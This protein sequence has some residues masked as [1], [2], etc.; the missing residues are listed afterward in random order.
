MSGHLSK[1][2]DMGDEE[3]DII[4]QKV[5]ESKVSYNLFKQCNIQCRWHAGALVCTVTSQLQGSGFESSSFC[6]L[7]L[8]SPRGCVGFL[9]VFQLALTVQRHVIS[10]RVGV[11]VR[12]IGDSRLTIGLKVSVSGC[13]SLYFSLVIDWRPVQGVLCILPDDG[14]AG[15]SVPVILSRKSS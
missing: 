3:H 8:C 11:G 10:F 13:L 4:L 9:W 6:S 7:V 5:Q 15:S 12:L 2:F 1:V 14:W